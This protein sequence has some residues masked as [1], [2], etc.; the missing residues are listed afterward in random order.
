MKKSKL[1][2]LI[3]VGLSAIMIFTLASCGG[4]DSSE[5]E[6]IT[7]ISREEGSGTRDAFTELTGVL[8][9]DV[10]RTVDTAEISNSTSVVIQSVAGNTAAIGYIS[11]GSLDDTVKAVTV[12]GV[13]ATV[14]N[15]KSGDYA[16]QRPFNI[17][18]NGE[19][20]E[21]AQDFINYIMSSD[22]QA[23]IEEEGYISVNED[24]EPYS[25]SGM[26][27][28]VTLAGSTSVSPVM[29]VLADRYN[30]INPDAVIEIQQTGSGAGIQ[31]TIEGACD[32]GMASRAL[33]DEEASQGLESQE[34]ALDGIAVIVNNE[35]S[36]ENLT[37]EQ[38]MQI[39]IGEITNW[40]DVAAE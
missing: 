11:L 19:V 28:T 7:V 38:I 8:E 40:A 9:D 22:G 34:I 15:V 4:G 21:L 2:K 14:D 12:D 25:G 16:L 29:E 17:V 33:E 3:T 37:T 26:S 20:S 18:T 27:G 5:G 35:N 32:I 23:V 36:V 30:E 24:A 31:S 39:F 1:T 6:D 10:D 13:E